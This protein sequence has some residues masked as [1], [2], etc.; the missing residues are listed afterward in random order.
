MI[1]P[2]KKHKTIFL[3]I[4]LGLLISINGI[5]WGK[6]EEWNPDQMVFRELFYK[7]SL[8]FN[9]EWFLRPPFH[10]YFNYFLSLMPINKI[11]MALHWTDCQ[12]QIITLIWSRLLTVFLFLGSAILIYLIVNNFFGLFSANIISIFFITSAGI[13]SYVHYLTTDIPVLF[14]MLLS[15][16]FAQKIYFKKNL[17]PYFLSGFFA[18][19]ATA[20]KYNS[21][22]IIFP[23]ITFHF[24][25]TSYLPW[26]KKVFNKKLFLGLIMVLI[27]FFLGNPFAVI[28]YQHFLLDFRYLLIT[29]KLYFITKAVG[30]YGY[31]LKLKDLFGL[32][33]LLLLFI[34]FFYSCLS[35][36]KTRRLNPHSIALLTMLPIIFVYI[37]FFTSYSTDIPTR[38]L[39]PLTPYIIMAGGY[40]W[41]RLEKYNEIVYI[42][43]FIIILYNLI[44]CYCVGERF[45]LDP[46]MKA[47]LWVK[48]NISPNKIIEN[49]AHV[50]NWNNCNSTNL[51]IIQDPYLSNR[52]D[53]FTK[54]PND[55][56]M[57]NRIVELEGKNRQNVYSEERLI[58]LQPDYIAIDSLSYQHFFYSY[59]K[60]EY[61]KINLFFN[62]LLNERLGYKI[63]FDAQSSPVSLWLYPQ[64][65]DFLDNRITIFT[66][67]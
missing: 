31:F 54:I 28:D 22:I 67:K 13:L 66:K 36:L 42:P 50:P 63:I 57:I 41:Q 21:F 17:A 64:N 8:P 29:D 39:L 35:A 10:T 59:Y 43:F 37:L 9:P 45:K 46:R 19:I 24:L 48:E 30:W 27:G 14:W 61:P 62:D 20:T 1:N 26:Q 60:R 40:F 18:G 16:Y 44:S 38:Y 11:S 25:T 12:T 3:I 7:N 32:P 47:L 51:V 55:K 23:L 5:G 65:I 56:N 15:Y 4:I 53:V 58:K 49:S 34:T 2:L 6:T 52:L 33:G